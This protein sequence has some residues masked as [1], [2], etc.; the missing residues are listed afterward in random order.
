MRCSWPTVVTVVVALQMA[1]GFLYLMQPLSTTGNM[2]AE[3]S[4]HQRKGSS[5]AA[6]GGHRAGDNQVLAVL[7][8]GGGGG[9]GGGGGDGDGLKRALVKPARTSQSQ[10]RDL[11]AYTNP[12]T[13]ADECSGVSVF[14]NKSSTTEHPRQPLKPPRA[15]DISQLC[16]R[17]LRHWD[18]CSRG[19]A[20]T[21]QR[22]PISTHNV[23][24]EWRHAY[25]D[26][27]TCHSSVVS[28][29]HAITPMQHVRVLGAACWRYQ[30]S[31]FVLGCR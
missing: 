4:Q 20:A 24:T 18:F 22:N 10:Q 12:L 27:G 1:V 17:A 2:A 19:Q 30:I 29:A 15:T 25:I 8:D 11:K 16:G 31:P 13:A 28:S 3:H 9:G 23:I 26:D 5:V 7:V 6:A 14:H 21:T